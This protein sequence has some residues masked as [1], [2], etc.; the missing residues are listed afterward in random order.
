M[1]DARDSASASEERPAARDV[2]WIDGRLVPATRA[3]LSVFDRGFLYGD[4]V[5][6]TVR[7]YQGALFLWPKHLHRLDG[8]ASFRH[9]RAAHDFAAPCARS[10]P[11]RARRRR[12]ARHRDTGHGRGLASASAP[13][14]H[15]VV[16][17]RAIPPDLPEQRARGVTRFSSPSGA[18]TAPSP[19]VTRRPPISRRFSDGCTPPTQ[20][21][22]RPLRRA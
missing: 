4:A 6:E 14:T 1:S 15:V 21:R 19:M 7:V 16:M 5:F 12:G 20:G 11:R 3:V 2:V 8:T 13:A 17:A 10:S 22:R 18:D 9:R